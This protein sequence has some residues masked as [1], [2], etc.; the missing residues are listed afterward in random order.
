M[1][2]A[3]A[4]I[5]EIF[6][7]IQE[8][9]AVLEDRLLNKISPDSG[10]LTSIIQEVFKAGGKRLRPAI[11]LLIYKAIRECEEFSYDKYPEIEDELEKVYLIAELS[12]LIHTA[13]LVHDDII[14]NSLIR[15]GMPTTNSKWDNAITVISGDFM[16]GRAAVNLG[17][18]NCNEIVCLYAKVLENLC[19]GE[20]KQVE[21]K[22]ST[23]I[24]WDY[25]N[26]K[27]HKKTACL[28]EA[29]AKAP[30]ALLNM[31]ERDKEALAKYGKDLGL[32]FQVVDD[33]LDYTADEKSLGKPAGSDLK[34]GQVTA[35]V[36]FALEQLQANDSNAHKQ[37]CDLIA[38]LSEFNVDNFSL[39]SDSEAKTNKD[40]K[41][42]LQ[43]SLSAAL[44]IIKTNTQS[45]QASKDLASEYISS[46]K[47]SLGIL[48]DSPAK[49]SLKD[50]ANFVI[51]RNF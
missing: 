22:Y 29:A 27:N 46:A 36:Y 1:T 32:A 26:T 50:L 4:S 16:F 5:K 14:D 38:E 24:N 30:A 42:K 7:P 9:L 47:S 6:Q 23:E 48:A 41:L 43:T 31:P 45:I 20:I 35:P 40:I 44:E 10:I 8:E 49:Q 11:S 2:T 12:E 33:I 17:K 37:L 51:D 34:D 18:L 39:E 28:F 13:S 25:Y 3:S 19:D 15:R 21:K